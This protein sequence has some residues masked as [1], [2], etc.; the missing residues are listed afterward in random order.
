MVFQWLMVLI[1]V[2]TLFV[3][4]Y[5]DALSGKKK[6]SSYFQAVQKP[7]G[8]TERETAIFKPNQHDRFFTKLNSL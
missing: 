6:H 2:A 7:T 8:K 3:T 4:L 1:A 5:S